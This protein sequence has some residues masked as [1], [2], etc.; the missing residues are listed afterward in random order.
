LGGSDQNDEGSFEWSSSGELFN[1]SF[2]NWNQGEPNDHRKHED[3]I[4]MTYESG[5]WNDVG[6]NWLVFSSMCEKMLD[7][8]GKTDFTNYIKKFLNLFSLF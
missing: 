1:S 5:F 7:V 8:Q 2:T 4:E 3:C 6:C